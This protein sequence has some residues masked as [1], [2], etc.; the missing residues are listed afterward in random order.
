[1]TGDCRDRLFTTCCCLTACIHDKTLHS[2]ITAAVSSNL[3]DSCVATKLF[4]RSVTFFFPAGLNT[5][6][7][8]HHMQICAAPPS[9]GSESEHG[10]S[11]YILCYTDKASL[12]RKIMVV[13][14]V[15][16]P[17]LRSSEGV[18]RFRWSIYNW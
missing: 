18:V 17:L 10:V 16:L 4:R 14:V 1:M 2:V 6:H 5:Q 13:L 8:F 3:R 11:T 7:T 12:C 9:H 15:C